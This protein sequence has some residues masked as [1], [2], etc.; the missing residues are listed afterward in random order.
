MHWDTT[1]PDPAVRCPHR[2]NAPRLNIQ[3]AASPADR[4]NDDC[5]DEVPDGLIR[6][7][8]QI[9]S[10]VGVTQLV[11]RHNHEDQNATPRP[12]SAGCSPPQA[13]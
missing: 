9:S 13:P 2:R 5:P 4:F 3:G 12:C 8:L 10:R 6:S 1:H 7:I 11:F